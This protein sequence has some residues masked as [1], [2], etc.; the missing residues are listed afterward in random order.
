MRDTAYLIGR[1]LLAQI[2]V[3]AAWGKITA[4]AGTAGYMAA[5]G[6]PTFLLPLVIVLEMGG[7]IL[8]LIGWQVRLTALALGIYS[9]IAA[10]IFHH[11][12]GQGMQKILLMSDLA[13]AGGLFVLSG[14]GAGR[15][16]LDR[17]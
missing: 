2:F 3:I 14:S 15:Y 1:F 6:V 10:I 16:S 4:Y 11:D 8:L 13:F 12:I 17:R 5:Y 7:G 9:I